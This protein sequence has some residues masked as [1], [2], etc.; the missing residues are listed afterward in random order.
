MNCPARFGCGEF[1]Q[2]PF[3]VNAPD[4]APWIG[5]QDDFVEIAELGAFAHNFVTQ[6]SVID[7]GALTF[8]GEGSA[9][10]ETAASD[11][12]VFP[13]GSGIAG[14]GSGYTVTLKLIRFNYQFNIQALLEGT[15]SGVF[16]NSW[17]GVSL[18]KLSPLPVGLLAS[19]LIHISV[20]GSANCGTCNT[21]GNDSRTF[22]AAG[23]LTPGVY[24]FTLFAQTGGGNRPDWGLVFDDNVTATAKWNGHLTL[25]QGDR[26][27]PE[28][29]LI[30]L[31]AT[32][33]AGLWARRRA[34]LRVKA[35]ER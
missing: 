9:G 10:S 30:A 8:G 4:D 1:I 27:V 16:G 35:S 29:G 13:W 6:D 32:A 24:Q 25:T 22:A 19:E 18:D 34:G 15:Q 11:S 31:A 5:S 23:I 33:L 17:A 3:G 21:T 14:A 26:A 2:H 7:L 20:A 12:T 28:P